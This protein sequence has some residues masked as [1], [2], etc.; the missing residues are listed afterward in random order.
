MTERFI[1]KLSASHHLVRQRQEVPRPG[2]EYLLTKH[3]DFFTLVDVRRV[4][5]AIEK[6]KRE[7]Q[8][9]SIVAIA[10]P[11]VQSNSHLLPYSLFPEDYTYVSAFPQHSAATLHKAATINDVAAFVHKQ[12]VTT[13]AE[14]LVSNV[15]PILYRLVLEDELISS[16]VEHLKSKE[17]ATDIIKLLALAFKSKNMQTA[18]PEIDELIRQSATVLSSLLDVTSV[19]IHD[20]LHTLATTI[21]DEPIDPA[22][23]LTQ[24]HIL[25]D[26][27]YHNELELLRRSDFLRELYRLD[28]TI[29]PQG[30]RKVPYPGIWLNLQV[31]DHAQTQLVAD[32]L[33][34]AQRDAQTVTLPVIRSVFPLV[35]TK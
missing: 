35:E 7:N 15:E 13:H 14:L 22:D 31:S 24:A 4:A 1:H 23:R 34:A 11:S 20:H 18:F 30:L 6:A 5:K 33:T 2:L 9:L 26:T 16:L 19:S 10:C 8:P 3:F 12:G 21:S 17:D 27:M 29:L 28:T 25:L 32:A